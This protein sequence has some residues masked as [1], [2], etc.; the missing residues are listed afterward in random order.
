M[1]KPYRLGA[2]PFQTKEFDCSS[3][4]QYLYSQVDGILP[5]T[6]RQ[7]SLIGKKIKK[8]NIR[9]GDLLFFTSR[10]R[11][12]IVNS[13]SDSIFKGCMAILN[14]CHVS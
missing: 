1:S 6:S 14:R 2:E 7:Q 11:Y 9:R 3:F 5:R 8:E 10:A 13:K 12:W 4:V